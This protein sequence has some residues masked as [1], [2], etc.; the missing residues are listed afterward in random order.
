MG[1]FEYLRSKVADVLEVVEGL[2]GR[3]RR[4]H[5]APERTSKYGYSGRKVEARAVEE[6]EADTRVSGFV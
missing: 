4:V 2:D 1:S 6:H 5:R 3:A